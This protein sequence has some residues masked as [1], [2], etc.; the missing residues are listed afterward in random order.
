MVV[1]LGALGAVE[2]AT[3]LDR[4]RRQVGA[5]RGDGPQRRPGSLLGYGAIGLAQGGPP[6]LTSYV[7]GQGAKF[8][9]QQGCQWGPTGIKTVINQ[10]LDQAKPDSVMERLRDELKQKLKD[11]KR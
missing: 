10:I 8:Y 11:R 1:A 3:R 2:V 7:L 4:Q 6:A 5:G 9:L